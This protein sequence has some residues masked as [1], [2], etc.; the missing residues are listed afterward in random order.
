MDSIT[1]KCI[2]RNTKKVR[3]AIQALPLTDEE[4]LILQQPLNVPHA[5]L[6]TEEFLTF[7]PV[8]SVLPD[9]I[10]EIEIPGSID[11]GIEY[12]YMQKFGDVLLV[13][14]H[15]IFLARRLEIVQNLLYTL[16]GFMHLHGD[17]WDKIGD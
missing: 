12:A 8:L 14:R 2:T 1:A 10:I 4:K 6:S 9:S 11:S 16:K 7:C 15:N 17:I 13:G 3:N 5:Q